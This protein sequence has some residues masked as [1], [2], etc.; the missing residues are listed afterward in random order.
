MA[1]GFPLPPFSLGFRFGDGLSG[2]MPRRSGRDSEA[3]AGEV[4]QRGLLE[5]T[6]ESVAE[7][8]S[9][10]QYGEQTE[11][12]ALR[13]TQVLVQSNPSIKAS[14]AAGRSRALITRFCLSAPEASSGVFSKVPGSKT[15]VTSRSQSA[16]SQQAIP[17]RRFPNFRICPVAFCLTHKTCSFCVVKV[18]RRCR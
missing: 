6:I 13:R 15:F 5:E 12:E 1:A 10:G 17:L 7:G 16:L 18:R 11:I 3:S 4:V 2:K 14:R 8:D 9:D